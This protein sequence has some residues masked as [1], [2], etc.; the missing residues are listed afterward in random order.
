MSLLETL[1]RVVDS[2]MPIWLASVEGEG[3]HKKSPLQRKEGLA[4]KGT[5]RM[6]LIQYH[7]VLL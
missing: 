7:L 6:L 1:W 4:N 2:P 5:T 3:S